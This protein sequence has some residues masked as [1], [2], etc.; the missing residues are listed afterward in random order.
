MRLG[1]KKDV[2]AITARR[3]TGFA[4]EALPHMDAV[5]GFALR[6]ARGRREEADDLVQD[7]FVQAF[8]AWAC[9]ARSRRP[10]RSRNFSSPSS[11]RK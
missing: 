2:G 5:Y 3:S 10:T 1:R 6:L 8:R 11:T 4:E 7:T 9:S